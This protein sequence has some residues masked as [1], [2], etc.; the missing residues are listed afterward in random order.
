ME[1]YNFLP[2]K[3][4]NYF[5]TAITAQNKISQEIGARLIVGNSCYAALNVPLKNKILFKELKMRFYRSVLMPLGAFHHRS[6]G[7][8]Y[9]YPLG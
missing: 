5:G 3:S 4:F 1:G 7:A 6:F 2:K 8:Y 9:I